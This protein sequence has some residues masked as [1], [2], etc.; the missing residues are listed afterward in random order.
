MRILSALIAV[1]IIQTSFGQGKGNCYEV[2][3]LDFFGLEGL[4]VE[5]WPESEINGLLELADESKTTDPTLRTNFIIPIIVYQ[6]QVFH[7]KCNVDTDSIYLN[8]IISVYERIRQFPPETLIKKS[9]LQ[10]IDF[11]RDDFYTLVKDDCELIQMSFTLDDGPFY[12]VNIDSAGVTIDSIKTDFGNIVVSR[13]DGKSIITATDM[14]GEVIWRKAIT[15]GPNSYL[16]V[17]SSS[18]N[19][20]NKTSLATIMYLSANGERL[21]LYLKNNGQ[22]MHYF[23]SW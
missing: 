10:K 3:Y 6:L 21:T 18:G 1:I 22:F 17:V 9:I 12:G 5:K 16:N 15:R 4:V 23:H 13:L 11:I 19:K 20:W 7:P 8:G 2:K 14:L